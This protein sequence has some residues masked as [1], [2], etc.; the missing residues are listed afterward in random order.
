MNNSGCSI[1]ILGTPIFFIVLY[2]LSTNPV[3]LLFLVTSIIF[4]GVLIK[5]TTVQSDFEEKKN[6]YKVENNCDI[7]NHRGTNGPIS[8]GEHYVWVRD[9]KLHFFPAKAKSDVRKHILYEIPLENIEHYF[10]D[11]SKPDKTFLRLNYYISDGKRSMFFDPKDYET[12]SKI[13][14]DVLIE[15][16]KKSLYMPPKPPWQ[17]T[18]EFKQ[19]I[20]VEVSKVK[21]GFEEIGTIKEKNLN[22]GPHND[23][24]Y[25]FLID[26]QFLI[27]N[28]NY[29]I[30]RYDLEKEVSISE[31]IL[32]VRHFLDNKYFFINNERKEKIEEYLKDRKNN[33]MKK[34]DDIKEMLLKNTETYTLLMGFLN[35]HKQTYK[36]IRVFYVHEDQLISE[37]FSQP[38]QVYTEFSLTYNYRK[39]IESN[40][41]IL[42]DLLVEK[43]YIS[44]K[45]YKGLAY[46][47]LI[48]S[49]KEIALDYYS[50]EFDQLY[51]GYFTSLQEMDLDDCIKSYYQIDLINKKDDEKNV[52]YLTYYLFKN[53]KFPG[54]SLLEAFELVK[55]K[56]NNMEN[57]IKLQSFEKQLLHTTDIEFKKELFKNISI[58]DVD[59]MTGK[60]FESFIYD[61]FERMGYSVRLTPSSR[62][63]GIDLIAT[64]NGLSIG[65]QAKRYST[66]VSNKAIQEAVAGMKYYNLSKVI[67]ITNNYF[68]KSAI[69][70]AE[71]NEIILWDRTILTEKIR[72]FYS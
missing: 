37:I 69:Q 34:L 17:E 29:E 64:K 28:K 71:A 5:F 49:L 36:D 47:A 59:L 8:Y 18:E 14:P 35:Q 23:L 1:I 44:K 70:L 52:G 54:K 6:Y 51:G 26:N 66:K 43:N 46:I 4:F 30:F 42:F 12:F 24:Y 63:Q 41:E 61:L 68:T 58:T 67:V 9:D 56:V 65:I 27:V 2:L 40:L 39:T 32:N 21:W 7:V 19:F 53:N 22:G 57:T 20:D 60:E 16:K 62:D 25:A 48:R 15:E 10:I 50:N 3:F 13:I 31:N 11:T 55:E 38:R 45:M 33:V 72:D